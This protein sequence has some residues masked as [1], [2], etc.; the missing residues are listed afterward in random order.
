MKLKVDLESLVGTNVDRALLGDKS[1]IRRRQRVASRMQVAYHIV[2]R[3][4]GQTRQ[5][6][7]RQSDEAVWQVLARL[8]VD[9]M[10]V[11]I[12]VGGSGHSHGR[13]QHGDG[14]YENELQCIH[15]WSLL[16][17][18]IGRCKGTKKS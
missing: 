15:D 14:R 1:R 13:Q 4:V 6:R 10:T 9:H 18:A 8:G 2:A 7:A 5:A 12:G 17:L 3:G 11:D 16:H